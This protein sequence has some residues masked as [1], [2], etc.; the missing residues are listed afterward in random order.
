MYCC[1]TKTVVNL[2]FQYM[3]V[4]QWAMVLNAIGN[5]IHQKLVVWLET[6][7]C[8]FYKDFKPISM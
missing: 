3:N 1:I 8:R 2:E 7:T 5:L 6:L 4:C